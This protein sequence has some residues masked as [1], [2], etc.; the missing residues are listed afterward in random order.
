MNESS[1]F[2][3]E[4]DVIFHH[5]LSKLYDDFNAE[6]TNRIEDLEYAFGEGIAD[7]VFRLKEKGYISFVE[8][9]V[10]NI[11]FHFL[12][13]NDNGIEAFKTTYNPEWINYKKAEHEKEKQQKEQ[14]FKVTKSSN[15]WTKIGV[16]AAVVFS[17]FSLIMSILKH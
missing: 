1:A 10:D 3:D 7:Y 13:I 6:K 16:I 2:T 17:V 14:E 4:D 15:N 5:I 11:T 9:R 12:D 8:T